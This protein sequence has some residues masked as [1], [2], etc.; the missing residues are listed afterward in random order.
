[1]TP[2]ERARQLLQERL[3]F[4]AEFANRKIHE[5]VV[6]CRIYECAILV[7]A[8]ALRGKK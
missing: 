2:E 3:G 5:D 1:M 6:V 4:G 8:D 7:L